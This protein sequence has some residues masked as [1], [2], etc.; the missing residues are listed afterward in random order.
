MENLD[1]KSFSFMRINPNH[2]PSSEKA[3]RAVGVALMP[4]SFD[5]VIAGDKSTVGRAF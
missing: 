1:R 4:L 2:I 3:V 5:R